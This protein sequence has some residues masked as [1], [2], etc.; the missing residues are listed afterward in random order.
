MPGAEAHLVPDPGVLYY[1]PDGAEGKA[2]IRAQGDVCLALTGQAE[3]PAG[4]Q[5]PIRPYCSI[6]AL[7]R[8]LP[9]LMPPNRYFPA[10]LVLVTATSCSR[11]TPS[12]VTSW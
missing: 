10:E 8:Y 9:P 12:T 11:V 7:T 6:L 2:G 3:G 4:V 5:T 1:Q